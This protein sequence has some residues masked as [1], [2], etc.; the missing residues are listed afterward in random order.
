MAHPVDTSE[1]IVGILT[2][3]YTTKLVYDRYCLASRVKISR[4]LRDHF[5]GLHRSCFIIIRGAPEKLSGRII[6][7]DSWFSDCP[8]FGRIL[9]AIRPDSRILKLAFFEYLFLLTSF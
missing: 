1:K 7:P 4:R 6:R 8:V 9:L 5:Q 2:T 3:Y